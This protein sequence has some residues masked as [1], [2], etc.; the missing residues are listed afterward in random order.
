MKNANRIPRTT[1]QFE[2]VTEGATD[3]ALKV[4]GVEGGLAEVCVVI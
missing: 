2:H 3:G 1:D 4:C